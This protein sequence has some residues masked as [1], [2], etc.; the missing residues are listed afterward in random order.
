MLIHQRF[1]KRKIFLQNP[2]TFTIFRI[3]NIC[4]N[5]QPI[6]STLY[7]Q[8]HNSPSIF[9]KPRFLPISSGKLLAAD[10]FHIARIEKFINMKSLTTTFPLVYP[11][12]RVFH[13]IFSRVA[14]RGHR[15]RLRCN[16]KGLCSLSKVGSMGRDGSSKLLQRTELCRVISVQGT[17][18]RLTL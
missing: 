6:H 7:F 4:F 17:E 16:D 8:I 12:L 18:P 1:S 14:V 9:I 5:P 10:S 3:V 15:L 2:L 11:K 13:R